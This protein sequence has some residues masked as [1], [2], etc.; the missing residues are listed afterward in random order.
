ML[1]RAANGR[2]SGVSG[3]SESGRLASPDDRTHIRGMSEKKTYEKPAI[4][5]T[6]TVTTRAVSCSK[7]DDMCSGAGGGSIQS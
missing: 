4:L 2:G 3:R 5:Q 6:Q 1:F 7:A